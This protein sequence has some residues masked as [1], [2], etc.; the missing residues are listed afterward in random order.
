[1]K[2]IILIVIL[3]ILTLSF[4]ALILNAYNLQKMY[5]QTKNKEMVVEEGDNTDIQVVRPSVYKDYQKVDLDQALSNKQIV[6]LYFT[7]NW[8]NECLKQDMLNK[9]LF[10]ELTQESL[11]G[12]KIHILD[13]ETTV[14]TDAIAKKYD[15]TKEQSFVL[16]NKDGAI[17]F[18][19]TGILDK[20]LLKQKI[21]E[22]R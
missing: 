17:A 2:K 20:E 4:L 19:Y 3:S 7:S 11:V 14:E 6:L 1:M 9:E 16:L 10:D 18:K 15:V 21:M 5:Y 13:S 12:L 8:C 22:M